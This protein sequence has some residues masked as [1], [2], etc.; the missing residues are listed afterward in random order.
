MM[1]TTTTKTT[2]TT[3]TTTMTTIRPQKASGGQRFLFPA[4]LLSG[5]R[6]GQGRAGKG[7]P[8]GLYSMKSSKMGRYSDLLSKD[9]LEG[10]EGQPES[11]PEGRP[12]GSDGQPEGR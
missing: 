4:L 9:Q 1:A 10:T 8:E 5:F 6:A 7:Q 2:T 11:Q 3:T 12:E